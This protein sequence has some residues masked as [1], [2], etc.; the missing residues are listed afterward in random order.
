M[1]F[2]AFDMLTVV[3]ALREAEAVANGFL[4]T[5]STVLVSTVFLT[6]EALLVSLRKFRTHVELFLL[7]KL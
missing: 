2:L 6:N 5:L 1:S 7:R 4:S 3:P